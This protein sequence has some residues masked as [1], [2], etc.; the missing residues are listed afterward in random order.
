MGVVLKSL[1]LLGLICILVSSCASTGPVR[2]GSCDVN[3]FEPEFLNELQL[4]ISSRHGEEVG[5]RCAATQTVTQSAATGFKGHLK[6]SK[7]AYR[8][9]KTE[10]IFT[11]HEDD[12][13]CVTRRDESCH[14]ATEKWQARGKAL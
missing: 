13:L 4:A 10:T 7:S 5:A 3:H 8:K 11:P 9:Q 6:D 2:T 12:G 14:V 1:S